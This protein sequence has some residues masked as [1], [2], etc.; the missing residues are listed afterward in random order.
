[1]QIRLSAV[2]VLL[3][4]ASSHLTAQET[5]PARLLRE[6]VL[7]SPREVAKLPQPTLTDEMT[8]AQQ[9]KAIETLLEGKYAW[10]VF[11]RN[12][13]V[14]PFLIKI[15][16]NDAPGGKNIGRR[17]DVSFVAYGS[18]QKIQSD[19]FLNS[20]FQG[21]DLQDAETGSRALVLKDEE[22]T[23]RKLPAPQRDTDP[24]WV[25]V[26]MTLFEK[27]RISSTTRNEK[28]SNEKSVF[29]ASLLD[30][31]FDADVAYPNSW[32]A[33][34]RD[35][36]GQ[37]Q[38]SRPQA[39][40]GLGSYVKVTKLAEPAGS[41]FVEYHVAFAEPE[42]WFQGANLLRSKLPIAA[43]DS[44]RRFRRSLGEK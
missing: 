14:A 16:D 44:V 31:K 1:M 27:V 28:V 15:A 2:L 40:A 25:A 42:G 5:L 24:R 3:C 37:K 12:S 22:L 4:L 10:E 33:I 32:R 20:R 9:R 36:K 38:L 29:V 26:D 43:Q 34:S 11:T 41:L 7:I 23:A 17:V 6:G 13:V 19:E 18:L 21:S 30:P 8:P 39:Y 35:D